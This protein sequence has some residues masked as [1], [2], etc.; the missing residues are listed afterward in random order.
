MATSKQEK[1]VIAFYS[2]KPEKYPT[3]QRQLHHFSNFSPDAIVVDGIIYPTSEHYFQSQKTTDSA[4]RNT[5]RNASTP[6]EAAAMGRDKSHPIR[7][8]WDSVRDD[9]MLVALRAKF[10]QQSRCRDA[11]LG[12][13]DAY[14]EERTKN[15]SY[16]GTGSDLP[17]GSGKNR[18]GILLMQV[19]SE[20]V[21][22]K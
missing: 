19:R 22:S 14:L 8:D 16:W 4:R 11:L 20:L 13:G 1:S 21:K 2:H 5:I 7:P 12:T 10:T 15:D 3:N 17:N 9:V 18:L 6:A